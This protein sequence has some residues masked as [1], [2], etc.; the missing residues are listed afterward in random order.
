[1]LDNGK[2]DPSIS[3]AIVGTGF[4]GLAAAI[5]LKKNGFH[6]IKI[7]EKS[8]SVGGTWRENTY[9]GAA[10][11]VP[12]HLYSFSFEP[13][14]NWPRKYSA[15]PEILAYLQHCAK[16]YDIIPHIQFQTEIESANWDENSG[17]WKIR[18]TK[19]ESFEYNIFISAVGQLNRPAL[20]ELKGL[21][22]FSG[23]IFHSANWDP[24]YNFAGKNVAAVGTGASAIQFIPQ[25]VNQGANVTIF[26]RTAPWVVPKP[27][28]EYFG[29]EKFL[30]KYLPGYRLLHRFQIYIWNEIRMIAFQKNNHANKIVKW[31]SLSHMRKFIKDP[32]LREILT[33][34]YPVGCKR[35]LLSNDY[36]EALAKPNVSV[37]SESIS[38]I[39]KDGILT[40]DGQFRKFDALVF[41]TGFKATEFLSPMK[42]KGVQNLDLNDA[43]KSG[44]EAYLGVAVSGFPNFYILYGPNTNLAH[45]SIVFMI[46]SQVRYIISALQEMRKKGI[47]SL[48]PK[49]Q[50]MKNYNESLGSKFD[51]FVWDTG[52][53]S[54]YI[55]ESGKNTNNWP[56]H[57]YEYSFRTRKI[58]LNGYDIA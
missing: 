47:R 7:F 41:G 33:P 22:T 52:C 20:P 13:N 9:P 44:A 32:K 43:W 35:I 24:S 42:I 18:T 10:C 15:Q 30:F 34:D 58:D 50:T 12:S 39:Q 36:Y 4:G 8:N 27:D 5:Q 40:K 16:K 23:K 37:T 51:K 25:I 54:W 1:M 31:M 38:E 21:E 14:P 11:D 28:R 45:N 46:E 53:T 29:F 56:G 3:I 19:N 57:T 26:Q 2:K 48:T 6:N 17:V 49:K 55:N